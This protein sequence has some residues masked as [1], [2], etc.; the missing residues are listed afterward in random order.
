MHVVS[1]QLG[2]HKGRS[3]NSAGGS[4]TLNLSHCLF[5]SE[6]FFVFFLFVESGWRG[7]PGGRKR[8]GGRGGGGQL[9]FAPSKGCQAEPAAYSTRPSLDFCSCVL[10][11]SAANALY[12][13]TCL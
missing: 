13:K 3:W 2:R 4:Q 5:L 12:I 11:L 7:E 8:G 10:P 9:H 1:D 6:L